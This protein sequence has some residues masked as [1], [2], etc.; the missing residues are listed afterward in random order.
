M[1]RIGRRISEPLTRRRPGMLR[2]MDL[3]PQRFPGSVS[4]KWINIHVLDRKTGRQ[5]PVMFDIK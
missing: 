4:S 2:A 3:S 1:N 5:P